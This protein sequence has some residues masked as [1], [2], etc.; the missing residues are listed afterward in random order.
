MK[1]ISLCPGAFWVVAPDLKGFG[2]S[3]KPFLP[4]NYTDDVIVEVGFHLRNYSILH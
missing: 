2:D 4:N 3:E 1:D